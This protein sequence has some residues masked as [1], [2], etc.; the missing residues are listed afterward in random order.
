MD[1]GFKRGIVELDFMMKA[2]CRAIFERRQNA[3]AMQRLVEARTGRNIEDILEE[4]P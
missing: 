2:A 4:M 3:L 1:G